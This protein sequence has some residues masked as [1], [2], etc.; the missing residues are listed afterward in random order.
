MDA[1]NR[2]VP[3]DQIIPTSMSLEEAVARTRAQEVIVAVREQR[4]G[5]LPLSHLLNCR[6]RGVRILD[7][8]GFYERVTGEVPVDSLRAA[9]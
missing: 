2:A 7:L 3:S 6:L 9:G 1:V 8:P 5:S 4:G